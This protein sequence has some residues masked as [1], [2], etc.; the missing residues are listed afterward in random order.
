M[1]I[2]SFGLIPN[3][4]YLPTEF[5]DPN[6]YVVVD[7]YLRILGAKDIWAIGD[8][9]NCEWNQ[10]IAANKQSA[11]LATSIVLLLNNGAPPPYKLITHRKYNSH[12]GVEK[13][14]NGS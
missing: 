5:V 1:Y 9:S 7:S 12:H 14:G 13:G 2:P 3:S 8:V 11:Y 6:G 10:L 4:S